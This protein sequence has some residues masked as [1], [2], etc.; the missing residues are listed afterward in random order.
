MKVEEQLIPVVD[1]LSSYH[2][3]RHLDILTSRD[4]DDNDDADGND[5][6]MSMTLNT[7]VEK[8]PPN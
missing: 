3:A 8:P 7:N 4:A 2:A 6:D 1:S 5:D